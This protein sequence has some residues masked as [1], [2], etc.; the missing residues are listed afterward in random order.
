MGIFVTIFSSILFF[1]FMGEH[2]ASSNNDID[3]AIDTDKFFVDNTIPKKQAST[4]NY[5][6]VEAEKALIRTC[7]MGQSW[8]LACKDCYRS[9]NAICPLPTDNFC[10][11][12]K[13]LEM[14]NTPVFWS[15]LPNANGSFSEIS[16]G[17]T[18]SPSAMNDVS[19][20]GTALRGELNRVYD[21]ART[22]D[23]KYYRPT[24]NVS[25][26]CAISSIVGN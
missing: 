15:F 2:I 11:S 21:Y 14:T 25:D 4:E 19:E 8:V 16:S 23:Y 1:L 6:I 13:T 20:L 17:A 22:Q 7:Q 5:Q 3:T 10:Q 12:A 9:G 24:V 26:V 18:I